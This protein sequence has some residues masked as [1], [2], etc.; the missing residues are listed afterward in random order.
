MTRLPTISVGMPAY[1]AAKTIRA[2]IESI[3]AQT[4][5]DFELIVSDNASTDETAEVV[6]ALARQDSR[7]R[8]I[9]QHENIGANPNYSAVVRAARGRYFKWASS[10]DWFA[11]TFLERCLAALEADE[12]V[13]VA[14]PRTRLFAGDLAA[15]TDYADDIELIDATPLERLR[16]L[17]HDLR[18]NNAMNGLIRMS[19]LQRTRLI[20]RYYQA[21]EVLVGHLALLGKIVRIEAPLYYRR[22]ELETA[23][24]L[25]DKTAWRKHHYPKVTARVLFQ[26]WKRYAGWLNAVMA[27]PMPVTERVRV[28]TYLLRMCNWERS[29]FVHDVGGAVSY[30]RQR[31]MSR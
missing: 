11:P 24:A 12:G 16:R 25:Q 7:I 19:A 31:V 10:S 1:N 23:T 28:L 13:V 4:C 18:L 22:M 27:T 20:D 3:L 15:A 6:G 14:A 8:Y 26:V 9:R 21:D 2:S 30:A 29:G 17:T 5:G